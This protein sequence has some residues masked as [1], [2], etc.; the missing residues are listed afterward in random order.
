[1]TT[2]MTTH[3]MYDFEMSTTAAEILDAAHD[4]YTACYISMTQDKL[5]AFIAAS[6]KRIR[7]SK[8]AKRE[9]EN[10]VAYAIAREIERTQQYAQQIADTRLLLQM[11]IDRVFDLMPGDF[12]ADAIDWN[13]APP[14]TVTPLQKRSMITNRLR[15]YENV[16]MRA[17]AALRTQIEVLLY[18]QSVHRP[19]R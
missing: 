15:V 12:S 13:D 14:M 18:E 6:M 17:H 2:T 11:S 5:Q 16:A 3:A 4:A 7:A 19:R 10:A 1:M 8:R 9:C